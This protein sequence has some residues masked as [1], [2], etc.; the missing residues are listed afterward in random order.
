M[1]EQTP[2]EIIG[3]LNR[4]ARESERKGDYYAACGERG[5]ARAHYQLSGELRARADIMRRDE[6]INKRRIPGSEAD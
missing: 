4:R 2:F 1:P 5:M 3:E 6:L